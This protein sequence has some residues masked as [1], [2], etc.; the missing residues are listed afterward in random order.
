MKMS[1]DVLGNIIIAKFPEG[2]KK[3][4]KI[5]E[6]R[7][8]LDEKKSVETVLEKKEKV[9]G[10]LRTIKTNYLAGKKTKEAIYLENNCRFRFNVETCYFSPRLSNERKE[11]YQQVKKNEKVLVMF[12][13]VAPYAIA[14]AKNSSPEV[15][16]SVEL[17]R[18]CEKY[19]RQN[20][21]LNKVNN[22]KIVQGDVKKAIP[23]LYKDK[24]FFDRIVMPRPNLKESFLEQAFKVIKKNGTIN[25]YGFSKEG[26]EILKI[27]NEE[28]KKARKKIKII[29]IKKAGDIAPYKFRWRVDLQVNN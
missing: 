21:I 29:R 15:V 2:A 10:R 11:I 19:A 23:K 6:A 26:E 4:E 1:Y 8:L 17:G 20:V 18:E 28:A 3:S 16:Y 24:I 5:K 7:K 9:K 12:G 22:V 27:I 13:G 14:I 25:Y